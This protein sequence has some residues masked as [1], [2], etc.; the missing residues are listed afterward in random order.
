[1]SN[2]IVIWRKQDINSDIGE[3]LDSRLLLV[4]PR[5]AKK[6]KL[7][8]GLEAIEKAEG[9]KELAPGER[10][11]MKISGTKKAL[12]IT[13][14]FYLYLFF[15]DKQLLDHKER[16][17]NNVLKKCSKELAKLVKIEGTPVLGKAKS[18]QAYQDVSKVYKGGV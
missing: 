2:T 6:P 16:V 10:L 12:V 7:L 8:K 1:M 18:R 17:M 14:K 13:D 5:D 15:G 4:F 3:S 9:V 11:P